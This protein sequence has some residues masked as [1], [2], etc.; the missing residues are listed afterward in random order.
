MPATINNSPVKDLLKKEI[1]Q[2]LQVELDNFHNLLLGA[3]ARVSCLEKEIDDL[4][5]QTDAPT[6]GPGV[7]VHKALHHQL[8]RV[9]IGEGL[10]HQLSPVQT[11]KSQ[12]HLSAETG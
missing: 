6:P 7:Q 1:Q 2:Y 12:P 3:L 10:L 11:D 8:P 4:K 9:S 5:K